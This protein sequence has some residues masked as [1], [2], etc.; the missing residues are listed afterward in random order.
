MEL[1]LD[2]GWDK[3]CEAWR[4]D[5][6]YSLVKTMQPSCQFGVNLTIGRQN[7]KKGNPSNRYL[8]ER[9]RKSDPIRM[10]S[11]DFRLWDPYCAQKTTLR[12]LP[13]GAANITCHWSIPF[14]RGKTGNGF[15]PDTY[16]L[17][18]PH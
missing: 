14:A 13:L 2:G 5:R 7:H 15:I 3:R 6:L 8:P 12:Y 9:Q 18:P 10:F 1:W 11:S 17:D 16:E 4:L